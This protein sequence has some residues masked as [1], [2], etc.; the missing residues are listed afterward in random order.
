MPEDNTSPRFE[1]GTFEDASL[2]EMRFLKA[3][4]GPANGSATLACRMA[5]SQAE[6]GPLRGQARRMKERLRNPIRALFKLHGLDAYSVLGKVMDGLNANKVTRLVVDGEVRSFSDP[7]YSTRRYYIAM[8]TNLMGLDAVAK[9][10]AFDETGMTDGMVPFENRS[11]VLLPFVPDL[12]GE[13]K[14][15]EEAERID[16]EDLSLSEVQARLREGNRQLR[17]LGYHIVPLDAAAPG[18]PAIDDP[19]IDDPSQGDPVV[20]LTGAKG[21]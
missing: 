6:G 7:D 5:G 2:F 12:S 8:V 16:Q 1:D 11:E 9:R 18:S 17:I 13:D 20:P 21:E 3:F 10:L 15:A 4:I 14:D 19:A